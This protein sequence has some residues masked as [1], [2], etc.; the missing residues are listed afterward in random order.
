MNTYLLIYLIGILITYGICKL[1][2]HL[3]ESNDWDDVYLTIAL[4]LCSFFG[5][6]IICFAF[7][8][9]Q[10]KEAYSKSDDKDPIY[11]KKAA[12]NKPPKW[13]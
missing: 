6:V 12:K 5:L 13:L 7:L 9:Y 8:F 4:S 10:I 2:R 3:S 11:M 1:T